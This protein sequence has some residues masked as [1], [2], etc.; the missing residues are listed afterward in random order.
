MGSGISSLTAWQL[1]NKR[2]YVSA[3]HSERR[4]ESRGRSPSVICLR[5]GSAWICRA[6]RR[7]QRRQGGSC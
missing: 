3:L 2:V 7:Y 4:R 6:S 1:G 5:I